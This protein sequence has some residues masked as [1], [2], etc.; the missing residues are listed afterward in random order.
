MMFPDPKRARPRAQADPSSFPAIRIGHD[1]VRS[2]SSALRRFD[3]LCGSEIIHASFQ[4]RSFAPHTHDTWTIGWVEQGANRFRR[5]R[6]QWLA[7]AGTVCVVNPGEV[8]TGGGDAMTYWNL[9]PS[10]ALL[11]LVFPETP[12]DRLFLRDAVIAD[13][14]AVES[15]R[16]LFASFANASIPLA[17]EQAVVDGLV[18]LFMSSKRI[19]AGDLRKDKVP[20]AARIAQD[21]IEAHLDESIS[22]ATLASV[23]GLSLFHFCRVFESAHGMPPAAYVRNR[24]VQRARQLIETGTA[25]ADAAARAG[26]ADQPHMTRQFR[27]VLG[28]TP[29]QWRA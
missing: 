5:G 9:M 27:A 20:P 22:L 15:I 1:Q 16:R 24:R 18:G 13:P 10:D 14:M 3:E 12:P 7:G 8:H 21:F 29:A 11:A 26:F 25:L 6:A 23:T 17:R 4:Q 28:V 2:A 19:A